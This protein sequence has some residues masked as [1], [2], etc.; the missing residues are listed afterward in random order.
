M[1]SLSGVGVWV[2]EFLA[3]HRHNEVINTTLNLNPSEIADT[4]IK[5]QHTN[6]TSQNDIFK[7]N[8]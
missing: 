3:N 7:L 2:F 6:L 5:A 1:R 4:Y 8:K